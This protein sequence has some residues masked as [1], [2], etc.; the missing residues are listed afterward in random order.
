MQNN[1]DKDEVQAKLDLQREVSQDFS[2]TLQSAGFEMSEKIDE[3]RK[4]AKAAEEKAKTA[5]A[6]GNLL[7]ADKQ[8]QIAEEAKASADNWQ[9][10]KLL[11][12]MIGAGLAA[13]TDSAS[14]ILAATVSPAVA[15]KIGEHFKQKAIQN[16]L[17]GKTEKAELT[18][19]Q[20]A[21]HILAHTLLGAAVAAA[22]GNDALSAGLAAGGAEAAA[23]VLARWL[24]GTNNPEQLTAEQKDVISSIA[25]LA[26]AA[27]GAATGNMADVV[28]GSMGAQNAV[29]SNFLL[30]KRITGQLTDVEKRVLKKI[31]R[32]DIATYE[33]LEK[34]MRKAEEKCWLKIF[35]YS[36]ERQE[37]VH[38]SQQES[39]EQYDHIMGLVKIGQLDIDE[40]DILFTKIA[41]ALAK[42]ARAN[43]VGLF[44]AMEADSW[45]AGVMT[46]MLPNIARLES[47]AYLEAY[48]FKLK[49]L[50]Y[51]DHEIAKDV[52]SKETQKA[53]AELAYAGAT[54]GAGS[55]NV[56]KATDKLRTLLNKKEQQGSFKPLGLGSTGR[57]EPVNLTEKLAMEQAV[58][59]PMAGRQLPIPMTDSRWPASAG[60]V[61]MSQNVNGV[62]I[63]YVRNVKTGAVDDFKFK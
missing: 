16:L 38:K 40:L 17:S 22:G 28:A 15:Y 54:S 3:Y 21:A 57:T 62:E 4:A 42:N 63:H 48:K 11:L 8:K 44:G 20:K 5:R 59:K 18:A 19:D 37:V 33:E 2:R 36:E 45:T 49:Q 52:S 53:F 60:W 26:G 61:K 27:T 32:D 56:K 47:E 6:E 39:K 43:M 41:P 1:F 23:P 9:K 58:S 34:E 30:D 25:G 55:G 13:P 14:G 24:Y 50:G 51:S 12:S 35:C 46:D 31:S 10:G 29:E 7:E